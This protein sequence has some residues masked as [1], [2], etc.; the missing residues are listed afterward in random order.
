MREYAA[1]YCRSHNKEEYEVS[2]GHNNSPYGR[3]EDEMSAITFIGA[4]VVVA[5]TKASC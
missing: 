1:Y 2:C 3:E 5:S 4:E